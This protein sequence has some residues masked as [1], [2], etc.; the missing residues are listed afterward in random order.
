MA[1][2]GCGPRER[3]LILPTA[4]YG[5]PG[6]PVGIGSGGPPRRPAPTSAPDTRPT[7]T[8]PK[9]PGG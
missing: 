4:T 7:P 5:D 2:P 9:P 1:G 8:A 6:P 3:T